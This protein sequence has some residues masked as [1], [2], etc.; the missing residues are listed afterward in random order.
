MGESAKGQCSVVLPRMHPT[1]MTGERASKLLTLG[2]HLT[3]AA[4][5]LDQEDL[6]M[7]RMLKKVEAFSRRGVALQ[8]DRWSWGGQ[9][10]DGT[11]VLQV[12]SD[13]FERLDSGRWAVQIGYPEVNDG[14]VTDHERSRPGSRE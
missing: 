8:N 4:F 1:P 10:S 13:D 14:T 11:L 5:I 6:V 7:A 12:W 3:D 9:R 2:D